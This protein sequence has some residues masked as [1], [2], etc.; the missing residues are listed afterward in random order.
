MLVTRLALA[1]QRWM[2]S[3]VSLYGDTGSLADLLKAKGVGVYGLRKRLGPDPRVVPRLWKMLR[4][5][6]A[7]VVHT[8]LYPLGYLELVPQR[9]PTVH[10]VHT[11]AGDEVGRTRFLHRRAFS[12]G[13]V[14][15]GVSNEVAESVRSVYGCPARVVLNGVDLDGLVVPSARVATI[16]SALGVPVDAFVLTIVARLDAVKDHATLFQAFDRF[17][18]ANSHLW[19]VGDGPERTTVQ[20]ARA[21]SPH[22]GRIHLLGART[23]VA[24]LLHASDAVTL[25]SRLEGIPLALQEAMAAGRAVV[26]TRVGGVPG[27]I[28]DGV[29]GLLA[30]VGDVAALADAYRR[31]RDEA[32]LR[33]ALGAAA[34]RWAAE[35]FGIDST[36]AGYELLYDEVVA[37]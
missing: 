24:D 27:M 19:V 37:R 25:T 31:L 6:G 15:V 8:H 22:A 2:P 34:A 1:H 20:A 35:R 23:D 29:T 7:D 14:P 9:W 3:V 18:D 4:Q 33:V 12:R 30:P 32:L 11:L 36:V 13:V 26:A 10:T 5:L 16:R 17:A 28:D 21:A